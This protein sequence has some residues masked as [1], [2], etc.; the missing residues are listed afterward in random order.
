MKPRHLSL[1]LHGLSDINSQNVIALN[2]LHEITI[3]IN[4][5]KDPFRAQDISASLYGLRNMKADVQEVKTFLQVLAPRIH[6]C[7]GIISTQFIGNSLYGL[8]RMTA[9][10][11]EVRDILRELESKIGSV[12]DMMTS[13]NIGN[14]LYG[15][16]CMRAEYA[17]VR[18][19]LS[20]LCP[21]IEASNETLKGQHV[22]N[23]LYGLQCMS[24]DYAEVRNILNVLCPKIEASKEILT[25]QAIGNALYG[26]QRMS[27]KYVEVQL[28][29][30]ILLP[31][32]IL[33][34]DRMS[35]QGIGM[36]LYGITAMKNTSDNQLNTIHKLL[37]KRAVEIVNTT[38]IDTI[39]RPIDKNILEDLVTLYQYICFSLLDESGLSVECKSD[40]VD[41]QRKL[42]QYISNQTNADNILPNFINDAEKRLYRAVSELYKST[43][44]RI[45]HNVHHLG[46]ECD[47]L[48]CD[49]H[50]G[51]INV[52]SDGV[53]HNS[54]KSQR[55]CSLRD[56]YFRRNRVPVVRISVR[57]HIIGFSDEQLK[58][59]ISSMLRK[60]N[61]R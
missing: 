59:T 58:Q 22:G 40:L 13:Q 32:L 51:Y 3:K 23:A 31:K 17:E 47:I 20:A 52:E 26:L 21:K 56:E 55:F 4:A 53:V 10:I 38:V 42:L 45:M 7:S 34:Q 33:I 36:S 16:Q 28:L 41:I 25:A 1:I 6:N 24:A 49:D 14:A 15:F 2:V 12:Q 37:V 61:S 50:G 11:P 54:R 18:K 30:N 35:G 19:I 5:C 46:F 43:P 27:N 29:L 39:K 48:V 8:R 9:D 60:L 44:Y 57:N